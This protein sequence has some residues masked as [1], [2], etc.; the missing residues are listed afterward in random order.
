[1]AS[2]GGFE[3]PALVFPSLLQVGL[4]VVPRAS[5]VR[6]VKLFSVATVF[7]LLGAAAVFGFPAVFAVCPTVQRSHDSGT[8]IVEA[9]DYATRGHRCCW[10]KR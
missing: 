7:K 10:I 8:H 1:L 3:N 9:V 5:V 6:A 4:L 2:V